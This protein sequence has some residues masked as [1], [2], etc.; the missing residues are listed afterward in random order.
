MDLIWHWAP[1]TALDYAASL[2]FVHLVTDL[3]T[4]HVNLDVADKFLPHY[5]MLL[6]M[7]MN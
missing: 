6:V 3:V 2:G 1:D 4:Q 7:G 5:S